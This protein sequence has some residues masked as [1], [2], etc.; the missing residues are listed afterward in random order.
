MKSSQI[1]DTSKEYFLAKKTLLR[2][3]CGSYYIGAKTCKH[4][5]FTFCSNC[6][7]YNKCPEDNGIEFIPI[8]PVLEKMLSQI[9]ITCIN[10]CEDEEVTMLNY[11]EHLTNCE[12]NKNEKSKRSERLSES[13]LS[14]SENNKKSGKEI[15]LRMSFNNINVPNPVNNYSKKVSDKTISTRCESKNQDKEANEDPELVIIPENNNEILKLVQKPKL[16]YP[17][18]NCLIVLSDSLVAS[19][20][21]NGFIKIWNTNTKK[22]EKILEGHKKA[23]CCLER[24][25]D[26]KLA[27][28]SADYSI[29]IWDYSKE[30]MCI[31][32]LNGEDGHFGFVRCLL[33]IPNDKLAS[34]SFDNSVKLWNIQTK[35]C[36]LFMEYK[37]SIFCILAYNN[38]TQLVCGCGDNSIVIW[39]ISNQVVGNKKIIKAAHND[40]ITCMT[41]TNEN[42]IASGSADNLIKLWNLTTNELEGSLNGHKSFIRS[43]NYVGSDKLVSSSNDGCVM[44]W[45]L[46]N[47]QCLYSINKMH[48]LV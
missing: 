5:N 26:N 6:T 47:G 14:E 21:N 29:K 28:G 25:N 8:S 23:V 4:C 18:I 46:T 19:G 15:K 42:Q 35:Q 3:S 1:K 27:S 30:E 2:C 44:M 45:D 9:F 34:G 13:K 40:R 37:Q 31:S 22:C 32:T 48:C 11:E 7:K 36:I 10:K 12:K 17:K 38:A 20:D 39:D 43:L 41:K 16:S 33:F 24:L